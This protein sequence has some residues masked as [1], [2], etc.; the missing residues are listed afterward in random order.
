MGN[1]GPFGGSRGCREWIL[2]D[3]M[4]ILG[5]ILRLC[6]ALIFSF[7]QACSW[8]IVGY[9]FYL[10]FTDTFCKMCTEPTP[11]AP[12]RSGGLNNNYSFNNKRVQQQQ[13]QQQDQPGLWSRPWVLCPGLRPLGKPGHLSTDFPGSFSKEFLK[14]YIEMGRLL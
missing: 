14:E 6:S 10:F 11:E 4:I 9:G 12:T 3:F 5:S 7:F 2:T 13:Q 1:E 8:L